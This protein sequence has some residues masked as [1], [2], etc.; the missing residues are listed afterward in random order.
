MS[1]NIKK[2]ILTLIL[3][4][5]LSSNNTLAYVQYRP[6]RDVLQEKMI[7]DLDVRVSELEAGV[8]ALKIE[9]QELKNTISAIE[10]IVMTFQEQIIAIQRIVIKIISIFLGK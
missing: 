3:I 5:V 10:K 7:S 6:E 9:N 8:E 1:K 2:V 4:L